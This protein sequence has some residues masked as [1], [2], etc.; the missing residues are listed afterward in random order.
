MQQKDYISSLENDFGKWIK[1]ENQIGDLLVRYYSNLF[2]SLNPTQLVPKV[3]GEMNEELLRPFK[4]SEVED[5]LKQME[6]G[7]TPGLNGLPP[8][9]YKQFRSKVGQEVI[10]AVLAVLNSGTIPNNL[11]QTFLTLIP[12]VHSQRRVT[13]FRPISLTNVLYKLVAKVLANRL[14]SLLPKLISEI[15]SAFKSEKLVTDNI[16]IA[17]ETLHHLKLKRTGKMGYM[18]LKLDI[19]KAYNRVE[20]VFLEKKNHAQIGVQYKMGQ[21][22]SSL[23]QVSLLFHCVE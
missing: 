12:K 17:N 10:K 21:S 11:Y 9:F 20:W 4:S 22:D 7:M 2:T 6:S 3:S 13:D 1:E 15:Q 23:L 14:K 5:A 16:L 18:A 19:R 8:L